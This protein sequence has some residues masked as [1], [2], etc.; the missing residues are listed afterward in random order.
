MDWRDDPRCQVTAAV[1]PAT[2]ASLEELLDPKNIE[3]KC[4][5]RVIKHPNCCA[6]CR[7]NNDCKLIPMHIRCRCSQEY[8]CF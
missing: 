4:E 6:L 2:V 3:S 7:A 5:C 8:V 1:D